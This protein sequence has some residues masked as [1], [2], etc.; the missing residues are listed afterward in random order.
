M[1]AGHS[2]VKRKSV[3]AKNE[4]AIF[5]D[6]AREHQDESFGKYSAKIARDA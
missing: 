2:E 6:C 1:Q 3:H 4:S 5:S